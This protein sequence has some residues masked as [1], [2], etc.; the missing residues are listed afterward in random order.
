M[1][2]S[3]T[4]LKETF[5]ANNLTKTSFTEGSFIGWKEKPLSKIAIEA[6]RAGKKDVLD[7]QLAA[8]VITQ[9]QYNNFLALIT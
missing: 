6:I 1:K 4:I 8:G 3:I 5:K 2:D 7:S 9:K